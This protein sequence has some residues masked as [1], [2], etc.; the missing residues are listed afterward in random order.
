MTEEQQTEQGERRAEPVES[1]ETQ[2]DASLTY[3][4]SSAAPK[5]FRPSYLK[6]RF[7]MRTS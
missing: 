1:R 2:A 5:V 6:K 3:R 7:L 4:I